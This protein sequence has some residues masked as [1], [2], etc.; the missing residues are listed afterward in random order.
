MNKRFLL[1]S[2]FC[3]VLAAI[4]LPGSARAGLGR[5]TTS[6][7]PQREITA[8]AIAP[9]D[10][11]VL[12]A[13][14][15][16]GYVFRSDNGGGSWSARAGLAAT[17]LLVDPRNASVLYASTRSRLFR[18]TDGGESWQPLGAFPTDLGFSS[19]ESFGVDPGNS[20]VLYTG[21]TWFN[22]APLPVQQGALYKSTDGGA[23]WRETG[24]RGGVRDVAVDPT[25]SS[26]LYAAPYGVPVMSP[27]NGGGIIKSTDGGATWS[28]VIPGLAGPSL[29]AIVIDPRNPTNIYATRSSVIFKSADGGGTYRRIEID[30]AAGA[31]NAL[32]IDP[33]Q[34]ERLYAATS[35][36]GVYRSADAGE[37]WAPFNCGLPHLAMTEMAVSRDGRFLHAGTRWGGVFDYELPATGGVPICPEGDGTLC[38]ASTRFCIRVAWRAPDGRSGFGQAVPLTSD[39]GAFW[40]FNASNL[41]ITV[42]VLDGTRINGRFWVFYGAL[43][44]VEYEI[45]VTDNETGAVRTYSNPQGRLASVADTDAF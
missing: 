31:I 9:T 18:S 23:T 11:N 27:N 41:E 21:V 20:S 33:A 14:T 44:D 17:R 25:N 36:G 3:S 1:R 13:G 39:T 8:L 28:A 6:G 2:L 5:W 40:F 38:L 30:R 24:L 26:V 29:H 42:K 22:S 32:A 35:I 45:T 19:V 37:T 4:V 43:S 12:Y 16:G 7:P 15:T 34:S 10:Q